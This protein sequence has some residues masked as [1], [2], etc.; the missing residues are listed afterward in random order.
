MQTTPITNGVEE[1][2]TDAK[3]AMQ[4]CYDRQ[5]RLWG[6]YGQEAMEECSECLLNASACES[7]TLTNG[8]KRP[9]NCF[10]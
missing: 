5:L 6:E 10:P 9:T 3:E 1:M 7:V 4:K 8:A 2:Q